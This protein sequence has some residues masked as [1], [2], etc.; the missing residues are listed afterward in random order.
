[1]QEIIMKTLSMKHELK[2]NKSIYNILI[3]KK[4]HQT[5]FDATIE[6]L[7]LYYG[8]LPNLKYHHFE[9]IIENES[10]S[11]YK[12]IKANTFYEQAYQTIQTILLVIQMVSHKKHDHSFYQP[13]INDKS[14]QFK[15][16][17]LYTFIKNDKFELFINEIYELLEE[18]ENEFS[19]VYVHYLLTGFGETPYTIE[20]ISLLEHI[21]VLELKSQLIQEFQYIQKCL[22]NSE[23]YP[24]LSKIKFEASLNYQTL[25]TFHLLNQTTD[26]EKLAELKSVKPHTIHDHIIEMYIKGYLTDKSLYIDEETYANFIE[27]FEEKPN[28]NLKYYFEKLEKLSYFE[29]KLMYVIY[30]MEEIYVKR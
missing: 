5:Y 22:E 12:P 17:E 30:A 19:A 27:V 8:C 20:Q 25:T 13:I 4:S 10:H 6:H 29:I 9:S 16:K 28:Q 2:T 23:K 11:Q 1:M 24:I 14:I 7:K 21:P 15:A 3:G 18:V 26:I